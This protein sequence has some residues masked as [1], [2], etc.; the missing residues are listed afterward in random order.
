MTS[1]NP[2]DAPPPSTPSRL[3]T[4]NESSTRT[5]ST[6][7]RSADT[8]TTPGSLSRTTSTS[9]TSNS[10]KSSRSQRL[11][12]S[13]VD[14]TRRKSSIRKTISS[15]AQ[16]GKKFLGRL[17]PFRSSANVSRNQSFHEKAPVEICNLREPIT[18][19]TKHRYTRDP[20]GGLLFNEVIAFQGASPPGTKAQIAPI[21]LE[22]EVVKAMDKIP[23]LNFPYKNENKHAVHLGNNVIVVSRTTRLLQR[24][25]HTETESKTSEILKYC[26][27]RQDPANKERGVVK[28]ARVDVLPSGL[29]SHLRMEIFREL[30]AE[31]KGTLILK[32]TITLATK[33][34]SEAPAKDLTI[35]RKRSE[36]IPIVVN[37]IN[38]SEKISLGVGSFKIVREVKIDPLKA[39]PRPGVSG[40]ECILTDNRDYC[41]TGVYHVKPSVIP[42]SPLSERSE[43]SESNSSLCTSDTQSN[44]EAPS[45]LQIPL[46]H[47]GA[48]DVRIRVNNQQKTC[49][50][51]MG[52]T[53]AKLPIPQPADQQFT[54]DEVVINGVVIWKK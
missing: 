27:E 41:D 7:T 16:K 17:V 8:A 37:P 46:K 51:E 23:P 48:C 52:F 32:E 22:A 1:A 11:K 43:D 18:V 9:S 40:T 10:S 36:A 28:M 30:I 14:L 20:N 33:K 47:D 29:D 45:D 35:L 49:P 13:V 19:S 44:G 25:P 34:G 3:P 6:G 54:V 24:F 4:D 50:L 53:L 12:R 38:L 26:S 39:V 42:A 2:D 21:E 31:K 5:P 15:S